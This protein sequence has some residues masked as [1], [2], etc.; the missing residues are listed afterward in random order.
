MRQDA[1]WLNLNSHADINLLLSKKALYLD[2]KLAIIGD[3]VNTADGYYFHFV[4]SKNCPVKP[5][6]KFCKAIL[7]DLRDETCFSFV[8][9]DLKVPQRFAEYVGF[10]RK[11]SIITPEGYYYYER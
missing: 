2:G 8:N 5:F 6:L 9:R 3:V 7:N 1:E 10:V 4:L 11:D